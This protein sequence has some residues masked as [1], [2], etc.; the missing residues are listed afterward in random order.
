MK[1]CL[2]LI[3]KKPTYAAKTAATTTLAG[4]NGSTTY[5]LLGHP[6]PSHHMVSHTNGTDAYS[7]QTSWTLS[8]HSRWIHKHTRC[9]KPFSTHIAEIYDTTHICP[10]VCTE[11][12]ISANIF[13]GIPE[14]TFVAIVLE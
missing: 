10:F 14:K 3:V 6:P 8:Y 9:Y 2:P 13:R 11:N 5:V 7:Q 12:D 4:I 1:C